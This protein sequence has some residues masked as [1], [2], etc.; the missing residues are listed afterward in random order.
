MSKEAMRA[1]VV[2]PRDLIAAVDDLVGAR[3]RS[4]FVAAAVAERVRREQLGRALAATAGVLA[5]E[6]H[7]EW[8]TPEDRRAWIR[9]SRALDDACRER[10]LGGDAPA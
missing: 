9:A 7:P 10:K 6:A 2:M 5:P 1:H 3:R 8:A 4:E